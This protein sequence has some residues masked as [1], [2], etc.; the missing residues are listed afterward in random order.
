MMKNLKTVRILGIDYRINY[1]DTRKENG[2]ELVGNV[3]NQECRITINDYISSTPHMSSVL[4]HE[5][6][7]AIDYRLELKL[8]H[9]KI[10]QLEAGLI[11]VIR[12]NPNLLKELSQ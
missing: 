4:L 10:T 6:I 12:D 2:S 3:D 11:Q 8:D 5:I 7:E 9:E 1:T